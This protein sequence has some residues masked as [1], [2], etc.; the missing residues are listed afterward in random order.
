LEHFRVL[1]SRA[2][3]PFRHVRKIDRQKEDVLRF[4]R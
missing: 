2:C 4:I 3:V 1:N